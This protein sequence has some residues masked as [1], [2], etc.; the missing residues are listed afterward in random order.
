MGVPVVLL[1][2]WY[3]LNNDWLQADQ[4]TERLTNGQTPSYRD[5]RT[6]LNK[7]I[8]TTMQTFWDNSED[9][10]SEHLDWFHP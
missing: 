10:S 1:W 2:L 9:F 3:M 6:L 7:S 4:Q 8:W 5:A